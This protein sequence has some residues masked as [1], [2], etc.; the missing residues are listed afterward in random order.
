MKSSDY[1]SSSSF[2]GEW[3]PEYTQYYSRKY[4]RMLSA[5]ELHDAIV[6]AT[7]KPGEPLPAGSSDDT[8]MQ[9]PEPGK[10]SPDVKNFLR[11]FGQ[12]NRNDM[13]K[14]V[15]Q[16]SLQAMLLM[17]SRIVTERVMAKGGTRTDQLLHDNVD[18]RALIEKLY[19]ST[20][21]RKPS[22]PELQ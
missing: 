11:T 13:P 22:E 12:R 9:M 15:P 10:A 4:V 20:V 5:A 8:V 16:S 6:M 3:K 7:A 19:L 14:K 2:P 17:Q 1:Q 21:S 18:D